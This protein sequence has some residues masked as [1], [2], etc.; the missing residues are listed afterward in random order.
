MSTY[1]EL[2]YMVLDELKLSSDDAQF[3]EDHVMFL[4][5]K[6]WAF[7]LKQRY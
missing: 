5:N 1:K 6:Y 4:L 2:T 3:T 7:I